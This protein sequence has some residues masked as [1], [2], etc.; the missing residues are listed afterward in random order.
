MALGDI[1]ATDLFS[2]GSGFNA[3]STKTDVTNKIV[4]VLD[5]LGNVECQSE[6]EITANATTEYEVCGTPTLA[7][8]LG[9]VV[10][11]Y[12]ITSGSITYEAGEAPKVTMSGIAYDGNE[13]VASRIYAVSHAVS[14]TVPTLISSALKEQTSVT[15][16]WEIQLA[17]GMGAN[18]QIALVSP[19]TAK[20]MYTEEGQG[21]L[22]AKPTLSG[23][24]CDAWGNSDENQELD[25]YTFS[26]N[27]GRDVTVS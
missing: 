1:G 8:N 21:S 20:E 14:A 23:Y 26:L 22:S 27:R 10:N 6:F 17:T 9:G 18:G 25:T 5:A 15:Y 12:I 24:V 13:T 7:F 19:R 3:Q 4:D 16:T 11:D 2:L